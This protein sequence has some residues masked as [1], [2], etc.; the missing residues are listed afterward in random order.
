MIPP[1]ARLHHGA[2]AAA[3]G[4]LARQFRTAAGDLAQPLGREEFPASV[5]YCGEPTQ[6]ATKGVFDALG[7]GPQEAPRS[8]RNWA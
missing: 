7:T 2:N 5:G 8:P 1:S 6:T 3:M 4:A